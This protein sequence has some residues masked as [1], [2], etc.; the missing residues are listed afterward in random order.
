MRP[1]NPAPG[2]WAPSAAPGNGAPGVHRTDT[3]L[4]KNALERWTVE[5]A[6]DLY[7]IRDWGGD[8]F[9]ISADGNVCVT[10]L[11][12][13]PDVGVSLTDI[14]AGIVDRGYQT[15]VLLR[16]ENLLDAQIRSLHESFQNAIAGLGY[17]GVFRGVYPIKVNQQKQVLTAITRFGR[18]YHHGLEAGSKAEL[19]AALSLLKDKDACLVCN[20]YKDQEFIDLGLYATLMG[21]P[22]VLVIEMPS[23]LDL[24]LRRS[25]VLGIEPILGVRIKLSAQGSG[26]WTESGGD[27]SIFGLNMSQLIAVVEALKARD[28]IGCLKLLHYHLGSQ[29]PNIREI[30][31]A[32]Q[33]ACRVYAGLVQEGAGMAFMDIGG[34]LA[35]D[36]DGSQT[37]FP[38]SRNYTL[39]E[40]CAD[41]IE[42][43]METLDDAGIAHPTLITESGRAVVAYYSVLLF[44]ILDV[45]R[46]ET[47]PVR[48]PLPESLP[49]M[50]RN[51]LEVQHSLKPK[52]VQECYNDALYY[53]DQCRQLFRHGELTLRE[54]S[55]S[56]R[57]FWHIVHRISEESRHLKYVPKA[58]ADIDIALADTYYANFSVFQSLP[59]A[60]AIDHLFPIMPIH[61]LS[62]MPSRNAILADIT[63]DCDGRIDTFIDMHGVR[64]ILPLH[65]LLDNQEYYLGVFLVGAYQETLGDLHNLLGDTNVVTV[66]IHEN[67]GYSFV[68]EQDGDSVADVL[69]Y[70][71]F[72]PK[73]MRA[74]FRET[75]ERAVREN[76]ITAAKRRTIVDAFDQGLRGYTYFER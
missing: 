71:A 15:P 65:P 49:E 14:L 51:L 70:V 7:H 29:L 34:G 41:V 36:Y 37:N 40:Y 12:G 42:A 4:K 75:A 68:Q 28:R 45:C 47:E 46:L 50:V 38:S 25:E 16:I 32:A 72:D 20:G 3:M 53:R 64:K 39:D 66:R 58:L 59:D 19:I 17:Q 13:K 67:G 62:E 30:R 74:R 35:V 54:R 55:L 60:W 6:A 44:N 69:S 43:V 33:E 56:E 9:K 73:L 31:T 48:E 63:C 76:R 10:P 8:Y 18:R 61:R 52:N 57:L 2:V 22:C 5:D 21:Y 24:I 1:A 26:H 27:R 11:P 23:E